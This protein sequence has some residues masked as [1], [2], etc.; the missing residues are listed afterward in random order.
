MPAT[1]STIMSSLRD[2]GLYVV[3]GCYHNVV[4]AGLLVCAS[5]LIATIMSSLRYRKV[6]PTGLGGSLNPVGM[7]LW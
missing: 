5:F 6:V 1:I 3:L 4:P 2:F 7:T